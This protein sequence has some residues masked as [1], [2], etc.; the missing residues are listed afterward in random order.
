M[1]HNGVFVDCNTKGRFM[2]GRSWGQIVGHTPDEF[3]PLNQPD[4]RNSREKAF[5]IVQSALAGE[6]QSFEWCSVHA[7]G[8]HWKQFEV[9]LAYQYYLPATQDVGQSGL[10]SGEYSNSSVQVIAQEFALTTTVH[11]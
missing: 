8:Y 2:Y 7:D 11:F 3:A 4:G 1:L 9:D 5:E 6:A 10:R